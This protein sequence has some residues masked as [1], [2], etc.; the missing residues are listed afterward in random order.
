MPAIP[1]ADR[2]APIVVGIRAT[3]NAISVAIEASVLAYSA[4]GRNVTTAARK[5]IVR[6]ARRMLSATSFG[7]LRRSAPST[8]AIMR[9][10]KLLPGS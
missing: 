3:S 7:V 6:P 5:T 2:S 1:I 9:S 10:R 4:N 8:S